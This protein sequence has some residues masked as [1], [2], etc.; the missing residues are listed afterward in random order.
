[1]SAAPRMDLPGFLRL[2]GLRVPSLMWLLG[3]GSSAAAGVPTAWHMIWEFKRP[4]FCSEERVPLAACEHLSDPAVRERIQRHFDSAD[5]HPPLD[6][7]SE[8]AHY[9]ELAYPDEGDRRRYS[10]RR[11][12]ERSRATDTRPLPP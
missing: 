12:R 3:A 9:F 10:T 11:S 7:A 4:I 5:G 6:D 8:Y 1:M 2:H